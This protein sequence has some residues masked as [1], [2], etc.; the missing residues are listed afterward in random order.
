MTGGRQ[1][2]V[3]EAGF[4][5]MLGRSVTKWGGSVSDLE[6]WAS[7]HTAEIKLCSFCTVNKVSERRSTVGAGLA[8]EAFGGLEG[9][10]AS[11]LCS[12]KLGCAHL[13]RSTEQSITLN[14][15]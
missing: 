9:L 14:S 12:Y 10:F 5:A 15:P 11:K 6:G 4:C 8:R 13:M 3:T 1:K 7:Q 2:A